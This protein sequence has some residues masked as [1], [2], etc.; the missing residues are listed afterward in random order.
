[1]TLLI[2]D[3]MTATLSGHSA[4]FCPRLSVHLDEKC[5]KTCEEGKRQQQ[6]VDNL[7]KRSPEYAAFPPTPSCRN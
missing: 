6:R 2:L 7:N 4:N 1:M 3:L 5:D